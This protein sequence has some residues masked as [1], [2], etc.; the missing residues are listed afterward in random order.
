MHL[1][2]TA[3]VNWREPFSLKVQWFPN[4]ELISVLPRCHFSRR[5]V[6]TTNDLPPLAGWW[7][8][9]PYRAQHLLNMRKWYVLK[10]FLRVISSSDN[11]LM[12]SRG[13][14]ETS[15]PSEY[16]RVERGVSLLLQGMKVPP[17]VPTSSLK[18]YVKKMCLLKKKRSKYLISIQLLQMQLFIL[19]QPACIGIFESYYICTAFIA[20]AGTN[21]P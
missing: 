7:M 17:R 19:L 1:A 2:L 5:E 9:A 6:M 16:L 10:S 15:I 3:Q 8:D 12:I 11:L 21:F 4:W 13:Y 18:V 20:T 14:L